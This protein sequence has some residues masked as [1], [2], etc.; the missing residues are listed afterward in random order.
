MDFQSAMVTSI[1]GCKFAI[2]QRVSLNWVI[3][4]ISYEE[5]ILG[6]TFSCFLLSLL[7]LN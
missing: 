4:A 3:E 7:P 5:G 6:L 2:L 1:L